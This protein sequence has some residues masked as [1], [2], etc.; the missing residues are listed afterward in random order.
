MIWPM[1]PLRIS[2]S[3]VSR[4]IIEYCFLALFPALKFKILLFIFGRVFEKG[5][6]GLTIEEERKI[7]KVDSNC[8]KA[9][10]RLNANIQQNKATRILTNL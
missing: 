9:H 7:V 2:Q 1:E 5:Y 3:S 10:L 8:K 6:H 4:H